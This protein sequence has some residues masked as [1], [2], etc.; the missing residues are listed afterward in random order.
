MEEEVR[1]YRLGS[2]WSQS[3]IWAYS[4]SGLPQ[5]RRPAPSSCSLWSGLP[6]HSRAITCC[7]PHSSAGPSTGGSASRLA[8]NAKNTHR[9]Q[10][11]RAR[12]PAGSARRTPRSARPQPRPRRG[13]AARSCQGSSPT[14]A[15]SDRA[16]ATGRNRQA[17][18]VSLCRC[19]SATM[20]GPA[21]RNGPDSG[22]ETVLAH[23]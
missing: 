18:D 1:P 13:R 7:G 3:S 17:Q 9:C 11:Y 6:S 14:T 10:A 15:R 12:P 8:V 23:A 19:S 20:N 5:L 22:H 4:P 21:L 16:A 2:T